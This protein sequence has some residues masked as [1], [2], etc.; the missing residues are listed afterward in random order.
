MFWAITQR[1]VVISYRRYDRTDY[2]YIGTYFLYT[3]QR[4]PE[5]RSNVFFCSITLQF[6]WL[7]TADY[8]ELYINIQ[9]VPRNKHSPSRL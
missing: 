7:K 1:V 9:P 3:S 2:S 6:Y 8:P 5:I 4:K